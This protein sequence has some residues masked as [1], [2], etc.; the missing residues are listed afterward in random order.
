MYGLR[1][2][3]IRASLGHKY[4]NATAALSLI[5]SLVVL[6]LYAIDPREILGVSV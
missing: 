2:T 6:L 4:L 1:Q 5:G 3:S